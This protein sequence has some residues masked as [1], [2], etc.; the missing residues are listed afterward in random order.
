[1]GAVPLLGDLAVLM[2]DIFVFGEIP[3]RAGFKTIGSIMGAFL[4]GFLGSLLPGPGTIVG[5]IIGGIAG[6]I[7]GGKIYDFLDVS[8]RRSE[9]YQS[10]EGFGG[11]DR[12]RD[13]SATDL[14]RAGLSG[15]ADFATVKDLGGEIG[16]GMVFK[17]MEDKPEFLLE[18]DLYEEFKDRGF[19]AVLSTANALQG[20]GFEYLRTQLSY[21]KKR[22]RKTRFIPI[23]LP[24][25]T[26]N[27]MV[28]STVQVIGSP[29]PSLVLNS[30]NRQILYKRG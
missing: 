24:S 23:G 20:R 28:A 6:D 11:D 25:Q 17:N 13:V 7:I 14:S 5:A 2:L 15:F 4:G 3:P 29:D 19:G 22:G 12:T 18:G 21:E 9:V 26:S 10:G 16:K 30:L 27:P 1:M 8:S